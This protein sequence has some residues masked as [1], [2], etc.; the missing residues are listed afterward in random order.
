MDK[1]GY[2]KLTDF[3][4]SKE[5]IIDNESAKSFCGSLAY[6]A[7]EVLLRQGHGK[8]VDWYLLGVAMYEMLFGIPPYYTNKG[9]EA[10]FKNIKFG[11]LT[12]PR[13][14]SEEAKNFILKVKIFYFFVKYF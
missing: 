1:E 6:L 4:L 2:L 3:G 14:V 8:A 7:P 13:I 12:F 11:K 5:G 10:L 9:K